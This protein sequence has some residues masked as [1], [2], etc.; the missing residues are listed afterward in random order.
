MSNVVS[1]YFSN[2]RAENLANSEIEIDDNFAD[3]IRPQKKDGKIIC[4]TIRH[5]RKKYICLTKNK[6]TPEEAYNILHD[7]LKRAYE[8]RKNNTA[9]TANTANTENTA[10]TAN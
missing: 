9:N 7:A 4:Y 2:K 10:N 3:L 8:I 1:D 5:K 6:Y